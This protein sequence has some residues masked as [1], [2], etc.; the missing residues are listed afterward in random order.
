MEV[1][2]IQSSITTQMRPTLYTLLGLL[3]V[4]IDLGSGLGTWTGAGQK[5][6]RPLPTLPLLLLLMLLSP[7]PS[8]SEELPE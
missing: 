7:L 3:T 4:G 8:S 2:Y 6:D 1:F 5:P